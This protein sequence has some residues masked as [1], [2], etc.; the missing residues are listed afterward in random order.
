MIDNSMSNSKVVDRWLYSWAAIVAALI[1]FVGFARTFY[2][3]G[4]FS[5]PTLSWLLL[6]HGTVMT[7]WFTLFIAQVRLVAADR[8]DLHRRL[9]RLGAILLV[10]ILLVGVATAIAA[11]RRGSTP[12]PEVSPLMFMAV[13][14]ADLVVFAILVGAALWNRRRSDTHKRLMLLATL[15]ILT[16]GTARI[17][18]G[19][20]QQGGLPVFFGMM[21]LT[22]IICVA[23]D[24]V[25]H[26]RLHPAF[27]WGGALV[28]ASVPLRLMVAGTAA[29][30]QFA[31]W[32]V[33]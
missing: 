12:V 11:A 23:V 19:F 29:W 4:M 21:V 22:V 3:K 18:I 17:P 6:V 5:T 8:T 30:T 20:I 24:T 25:K 13:P 26:R 28:I 27:G 2:L 16:P 9:G 7:L 31:T 10:L 15:S 33:A 1:I 14:L 32:L